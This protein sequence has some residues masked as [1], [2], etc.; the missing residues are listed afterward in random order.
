MTETT[1]DGL[2]EAVHAARFTWVGG[3]DNDFDTHL[4][5]AVRAHL[6]ALAQDERVRVGDAVALMA[7]TTRMDDEAADEVADKALAVFLAA[8]EPTP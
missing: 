4:A 3:P 7:I 8:L 1:R 2:A 5:A 6:A